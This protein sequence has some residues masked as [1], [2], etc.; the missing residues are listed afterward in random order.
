MRRALLV[1]VLLAISCTQAG[2]P[3]AKSSPTSIA[4][5]TQSPIPTLFPTPRPSPV[6]GDL[7]VSQV[8]F[9]CRLPIYLQTGYEGSPDFSRQG[10][11][12]TFPAATMSIDP[13]G[14]DGGY[15]DRAFNRWV[16][17]TREAVSPDGS[18]Y[19]HVDTTGP[20]QLRIVEV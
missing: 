14:K 2:Q 12:I 16:P 8:T 18:H 5:T 20:W 11:F 10:A 4:T 1:V 15:F 19:A 17:V 13:S 7:P 6:P 3:V 9:S